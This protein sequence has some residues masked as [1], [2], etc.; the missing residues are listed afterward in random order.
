MSN[1]FKK[2]QA[3]TGLSVEAHTSR[4]SGEFSYVVN[5]KHYFACDDIFDALW[6]AAA[7]DKIVHGALTKPVLFKLGV[8]KA[9]CIIESESANV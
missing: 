8:L 5:G 9:S 6:Y 2:I 1:I 3:V 4:F 7:T